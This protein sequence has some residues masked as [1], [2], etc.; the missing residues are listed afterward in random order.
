[1]RDFLVRGILGKCSF[2]KHFV[3][4]NKKKEEEK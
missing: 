2:S 4:G 3:S 1:M